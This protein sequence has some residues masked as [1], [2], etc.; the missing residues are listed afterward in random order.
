M[1][2][3]FIIKKKKRNVVTDKGENATNNSSKNYRNRLGLLIKN[4]DINYYKEVI[5]KKK[6]K[7]H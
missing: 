2:R 5:K 7:V 4:T 6:I 3:L 1:G